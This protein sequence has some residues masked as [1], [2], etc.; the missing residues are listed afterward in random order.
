V[1]STR[2]QQGTFMSFFF[3]FFFFGEFEF[4]LDDN[5]GAA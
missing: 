2:V 3:F 4:Y 5:Y 1:V